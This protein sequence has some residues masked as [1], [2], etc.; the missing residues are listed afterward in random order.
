MELRS[1]T[2]QL[3]MERRWALGELDSP[4]FWIL[5]RGAEQRALLR[6]ILSQEEEDQ[7]PWAL[8][9]FRQIRSN[10]LKAFPRSTRWHLAELR[11]S[12]EEFEPLLALN[13]P[14]WVR[15]TGG[16]FLMVDA[17]NGIQ[18]GT[19]SD[20]RTEIVVSH[21]RGHR[22]IPT[23]GITLFGHSEQGPFV[24]FEGSARLVALYTVHVI[25]GTPIERPSFEVVV[26]LS[27]DPLLRFA[28]PSLAP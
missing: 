26:G 20:E 10:L 15:L 18:A 12:R 7:Y 8:S 9:D 27:S 23:G 1:E 14:D 17:A 2:T 4:R 13:D 21:V 16:T 24:V 6:R 28:P 22:D 19:V 11:V 5:R 3:E 25:D